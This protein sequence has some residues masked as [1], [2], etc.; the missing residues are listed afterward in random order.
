MSANARPRQT[1]PAPDNA[2][3]ANEARELLNYRLSERIGQEELATVYRGV[4]LTL[5]RPVEVHVLR[6]TDWISASRFQLAARLAA[7][8][9]H[10][11][12]LSVIDAGHDER[13]GDYIV[14]PWMESSTL[15]DRL[16]SGP[17]DPLLALRVFAQVGAA[18]DYLHDQQI[19][20]RD[21]RPDNIVLTPQGVAYLTNLSLAHAPDTPDLSSIDEADF[22]TPYSA[23]E[24]TLVG[25]E[26]RRE[27]DL[28]SLGAVLY[29]MAS[30]ELPPPPGQSIPPLASRDPSLS[31]ADR[32][33]RKLLATDPAQRF[34]TADQASAAL[35]QSLRKQID[36]STDDMEESRWEP[37]AEWLENPVETVIGDLIDQEFLAQ[38]RARADGL[39]RTG[40][41]RRTLDR[42]SRQGFLRRPA[43]GHAVQPEQIVSYNLYTFELS[44]QY[45]TRTQPQKRE[46]VHKTGAV[47]PAAGE[48]ELWDVA[49]PEV[50]PFV[51]APAEPIV[52]PGSQRVVGCTECNGSAQVQCKTCSGK[53]AIEKN[54]RVKEAD[55]S[56]RTESYA[57]NCPTCRGYGKLPCPRCEGTGQMLQEQVFTWSR[58]G[59]VFFNEDDVAP[60]QKLAV[61]TQAQE[62][63]HHTLDVYEPRWYQIAPLKELLEAAITG[64]GTDARLIA[65]DLIIK[66]APVTEVDYRLKDKQHSLA[67]V[68]FKD[69]V[70]GDLTLFDIERAALYAAIAAL[71]LALLV[72]VVLLK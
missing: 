23:P 35:R 52:I 47:N 7:R 44:V 28:Y 60:Y 69:E 4:H 70:R 10:P 38:T 53:G 13:Y 72:T 29:Q 34:S 6:R 25:G 66:G 15:S 21:V 33:V 27:S 3:A 55:G 14:T 39:H 64:G 18:L 56:T 61:Q 17:L 43:L 57:E 2:R 20:H 19:Y 30:G 22:L 71:V 9:S 48:T 1:T 59:R 42:W 5:D 37:I 49:V 16:A 41:V 54:R 45:E 68:G 32:V 65:A 40:A 8:L 58:H 11:N 63:Y 31:S 67:L 51:N 50:E 62:V 46:M 26:M 12:I 36:D 24:Q